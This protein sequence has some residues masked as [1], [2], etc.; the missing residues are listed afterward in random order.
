MVYEKKSLGEIVKNGFRAGCFTGAIFYPGSAAIDAAR[1]SETF[2]ERLTDENTIYM[3]LLFPVL[4][5][6]ADVGIELI[7][8]AYQSYKEKS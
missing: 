1:G 4:Y 6:V 2:I 5:P 7:R 8:R 3:A